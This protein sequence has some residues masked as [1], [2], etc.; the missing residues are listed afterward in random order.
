MPTVN[1]STTISVISRLQ[2]DSRGLTLFELLIALAVVLAIGALALP[3]TF[4]EYERRESVAVRDHIAM[5]ALMARAQARVGGVPFV[6]V[7]DETGRHIEVRKIDPRDPGN[8]FVNDEGDEKF[9]TSQEDEDSIPL[10]SWQLVVLPE[11]THFELDQPRRDSEEPSSEFAQWEPEEEVEDTT[12]GGVRL[13]VFMPDG[14]LLGVQP[15]ILRGPA[16]RFRLE[17]DP[18]TGSLATTFIPMDAESGT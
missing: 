15:L 13:A 16:G 14:T 2:A 6:M 5:Q 7:L 10:E 8:V 9:E 3:F 11:G 12:L 1:H 17:F 4:R 18:W